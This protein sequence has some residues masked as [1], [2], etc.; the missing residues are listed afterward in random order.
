MWFEAVRRDGSQARFT[1][2][3]HDWIERVLAVIEAKRCAAAQ[4][5]FVNPI[6]MRAHHRSRARGVLFENNKPDAARHA[7]SNDDTVLISGEPEAGDIG[8]RDRIAEEFEISH[9]HGGRRVYWNS[10][11]KAPVR[12]AKMAV[13]IVGSQMSKTLLRVTEAAKGRRA[14]MAIQPRFTAHTTSFETMGKNLRPSNRLSVT[15][16]NLRT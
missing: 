9:Q 4:V 7:T 13:H 10:T 6:M 15:F 1:R 12:M 16:R 5:R 11:T 2:T 14:I 8:G 3:G